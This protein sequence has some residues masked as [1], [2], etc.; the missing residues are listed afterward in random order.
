MK[1]WMQKLIVITVALVTFGIISP[2][3]EIWE[4]LDNDHSSSSNNNGDY[5][6][7]ANNV[8][9]EDSISDELTEHSTFLEEQNIDSILLTAK[10]QSYLK[11]G[12]RIAPV[13]RNEFDSRI[14]PKMEEVIQMTLARQDGDSIPYIKISNQPSGNY[15][16]KIFNISNGFTGQDLIRFHVRTEKRPI[17]GYYYN[18]HYHT[19]EDQFAKHHNI[20][21]IYWSKDTP[22]KWLS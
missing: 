13:I 17:E 4:L 1:K 8:T 18:F 3:H 20:G 10:E 15:S 5:Q 6:S 19:L 14:L 21:E 7:S 22:P 11:F 9:Y 16:E 12:S 2:N